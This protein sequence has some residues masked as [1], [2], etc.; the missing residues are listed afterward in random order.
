M[1]KLWSQDFSATSPHPVW[2]TTRL[3]TFN[4]A[5]TSPVVPGLGFRA[6]PEQGASPPPMV[7]PYSLASS[8]PPRCCRDLVRSQ[9]SEGLPARTAM[10]D[11]PGTA[12]SRSLQPRRRTCSVPGWE[13]REPA[14]SSHH[15]WNP[16]GTPPALGGSEL[17][18][19]DLN[20]TYHT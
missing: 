16:R 4:T 14:V 10:G 17:G 12:T 13:S 15:Q 2:P 1:I 5:S 20:P 6:W 11:R 8:P 18:A 3:S 7:S 19:A 9:L